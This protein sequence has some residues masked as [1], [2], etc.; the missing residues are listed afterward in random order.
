MEN[1]RVKTSQ[2]WMDMCCFNGRHN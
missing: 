2:I 1:M